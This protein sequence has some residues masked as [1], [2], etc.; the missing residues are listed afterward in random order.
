MTESEKLERLKFHWDVWKG[1]AKGF[2]RRAA[3]TSA[4]LLIII[5]HEYNAIDWKFELVSYNPASTH[6][7]TM[8]DRLLFCPLGWC[9]LFYLLHGFVDLMRHRVPGG[10][11]AKEMGQPDA[12]EMIHN[13]LIDVG[14]FKGIDLRLFGHG[15][16]YTVFL[17]Y[18]GILAF[19]MAMATAHAFKPHVTP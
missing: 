13:N 5:L 1:E 12:E 18:F 8:F 7:A 14:P 4:A 17:L 11:K 3:L 9:A 19:W 15:L 6:D 10:P 2:W 16:Y